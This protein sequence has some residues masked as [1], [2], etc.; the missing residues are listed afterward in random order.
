MLKNIFLGF[1]I[2]ISS[3]LYSQLKITN[4]T[5]E[6]LY[7]AIG[8]YENG[9]WFSK[10][11]YGIDNGQTA[12]L[13]E[14]KLLNRY[15]YFYAKNSAGTLV[16]QDPKATFYIHPYNTFSINQSSSVDGYTKVGFVSI[17]VGDTGSGAVALNNKAQPEIINIQSARPPKSE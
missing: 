17:D 15:C 12:I 7:V 8:Y 11:W 13:I 10:G 5:G 6:K 14:H 2:F 1:F 16:F 3:T 4:A 9:T